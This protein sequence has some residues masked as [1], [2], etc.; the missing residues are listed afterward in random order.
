[1]NNYL[2]LPTTF[3]DKL[4]SESITPETKKVLL[5]YKNKVDKINKEKKRPK[6]NKKASA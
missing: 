1:M 2:R 3:D 4:K 6:K 5:Q